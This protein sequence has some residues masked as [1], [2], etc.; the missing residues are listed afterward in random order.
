MNKGLTAMGKFLLLKTNWEI[1][2]I[3]SEILIF[4]SEV[5][6]RAFFGH[7]MMDI[8]SRQNYCEVG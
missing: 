2:Q 4:C 6:S 7:L 1:N 3:S 8:V 5:F